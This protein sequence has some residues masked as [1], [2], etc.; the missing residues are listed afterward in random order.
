MATVPAAVADQSSQPSRPQILLVSLSFEAWHDD[1]YSRLIDKLHGQAQVKRAKKHDA[2]L[3]FLA[4]NQPRVI[5][6]T[7]GGIAEPRNRTVLDRVIQYARSGGIVIL[8]FLFSS[9]TS[10]PHMDA[11]FARFG[12]PWK[13]SGYER[14]TYA[15]NRRAVQSLDSSK[16]LPA[17]SQK[18]SR[19][20]PIETQHALYLATPDSVCESH[21][22]RP[23]SVN[24]DEAPIAWVQVGE[25]HLG[26]IGDV[27]AEEGSD[28]VVIAMCGF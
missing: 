20:A 16:L 8:G 5:I 23:T 14:S 10:G 11:L 19:V 9:L 15:L 17:Y 26:Y 6:L 24:Q 7:D 28:D 22:F 18:A 21:V 2:A 27:N 25:G 1:I 12:L 4:D 3:R 13:R